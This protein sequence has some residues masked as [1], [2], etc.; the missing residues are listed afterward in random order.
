VILWIADEEAPPTYSMT[1]G[2]WE[3]DDITRRSHERVVGTLYGTHTYVCSAS[4][5]PNNRS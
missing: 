1:V 3:T 5:V 4:I 2:V